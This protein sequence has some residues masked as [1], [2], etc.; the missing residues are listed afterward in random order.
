MVFA[1]YFELVV[2]RVRTG[3][4][5][6]LADRLSFSFLTGNQKLRLVGCGHGGRSVAS[7]TTGIAPQFVWTMVF[8]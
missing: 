2:A 1:A 7:Y 3:V 5:E 4:H 6:D 8:L